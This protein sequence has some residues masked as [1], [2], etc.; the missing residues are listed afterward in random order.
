MGV[1]TPSYSCACK[2][3]I[4]LQPQCRDDSSASCGDNRTHLLGCQ[5]HRSLICKGVHVY[6]RA[7]GS[8]DLHR[9]SLMSNLLPF[10]NVGTTGCCFRSSWKRAV[11][12]GDSDRPA[13]IQ[14]D[15]IPLSSDEYTVTAK[16]AILLVAGPQ[17]SF[18]PASGTPRTTSY[19]QRPQY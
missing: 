1:A 19:G 5:F 16:G 2:P 3:S 15:W 14:R 8:G 9:D 11:D 12:T 17:S 10:V 7:V 6:S 13:L 4:N 18:T